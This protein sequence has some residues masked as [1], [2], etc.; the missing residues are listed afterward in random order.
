MENY[1]YTYDIYVMPT[2]PTT[3]GCVYMLLTILE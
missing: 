3:N 1:V 2:M